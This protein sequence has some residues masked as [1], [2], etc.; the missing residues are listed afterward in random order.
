MTKPKVY[1]TRRIAQE[2]LDMIAQSA[3]MEL[4][5]EELPPPYEVILEKAKNID[6]LL[7]L[8]TDKIDANLMKS[9]PKL[10]VISNMA[11]GYDNVDI[12]EATRRSIVI[13]YTPGVLTETTTDF[14]FA[15]LM[16]AARRV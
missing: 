15:L 9:A 12:P 5:P 8:L 11:V 14:A 3:E 6:G 1:V 16:A 7:S 10:K 2:A 4:W 13:G